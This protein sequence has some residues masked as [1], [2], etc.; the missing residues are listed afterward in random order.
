M[1]YIVLRKVLLRFFAN[2]DI[3]ENVKFH[4]ALHRICPIRSENLQLRALSSTPRFWRQ[5][6][7]MLRPIDE[8]G[9]S[10][11]LSNILANAK[12]IFENVGDTDLGIC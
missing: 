1:M 6:I 5:S 9:D 3:A 11:K 7:A 8:N 10:S 12:K 2:K 4:S